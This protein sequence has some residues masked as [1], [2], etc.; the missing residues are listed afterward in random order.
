MLFET[1]YFI[2]F[3]KRMT[4]INKKDQINLYY[5]AQKRNHIV[6]WRTRRAQDCLASIAK[7]YTL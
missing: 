6:K 3:L 7:R 4:T 2:Y 5:L 1:F